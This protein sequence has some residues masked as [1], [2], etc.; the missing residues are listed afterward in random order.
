LSI[1]IMT[2]GKRSDRRMIPERKK[3]GRDNTERGGKAGR[4]CFSPAAERR[5]FF[6]LTVLLLAYGL[7]VKAGWL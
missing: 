6:Y 2:A 5:V 3:T 7:L 4:L 1:P